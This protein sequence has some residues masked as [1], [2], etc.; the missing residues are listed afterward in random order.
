MSDIKNQVQKENVLKDIFSWEIPVDSVPLPSQGKIYNPN[1]KLF[2]A[3]TVNIKS[4]TA[5][6]EDILSSQALIKEGKVIDELLKSCLIDKDIDVNDMITGD[7]NA[8]MVSIRITGYG[9]K[10][11]ILSS[12]T[13]CGNSNEVSVDLSGLEIKPLGIDPVKPGENLF[14]FTLP[15]SKKEILFKFLTGK[16]NREIEKIEKFESEKFGSLFTK[17]VTNFLWFSIVS[18]DGVTDKNKIKKFVECMPA[19]DSVSLRTYIDENEPGVEMKHKFNCK[20]C[21]HHNNSNIPMTSNF[22]WPAF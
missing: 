22:F 17:R 20:F 19:Y 2:N 16:E 9:S 12:C 10:Y 21:D 1:S 14:K 6:E 15:V 8:V 7:K 18:I 3:K 13:N 11:D 5:K 4:M